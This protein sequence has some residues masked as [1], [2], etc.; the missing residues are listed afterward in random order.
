MVALKVCSVHK[1]VI[2]NNKYPESVQ[3]CHL[4]FIRACKTG[5]LIQY[6]LKM[7][8]SIRLN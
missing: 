3:I 5:H 7:C 1:Y 4:F 8:P 2:F 6:E